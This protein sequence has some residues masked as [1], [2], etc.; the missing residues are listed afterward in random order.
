LH[1]DGIPAG[2]FK[3][4]RAGISQTWCSRE[5]KTLTQAEKE[6]YGA[7][8]TQIRAEREREE[9]ERHEQAR[10]RANEIWKQS[11]EVTTHPYLTGKQVK[12]FGIKESRGNIVVPVYDDGVIQSLQFIKPDGD[13][14]FLA[15][16]RKKGC[17]FVI[18]AKTDVIIC[19]TEGYATAVSIYEATGYM[20]IVAFDSVNLLSV[21]KAI[22]EKYPN[23]KLILCA[24]D[25]FL[26]SGN[27]GLTKAK[28]AA[29]AVGG[30]LAVPNFGDERMSNQTDF[31]DVHRTTSLEN[32]K[33]Q[34]DSAVKVKKKAK[35][36][37]GVDDGE[38]Q[39]DK[40]D[41]KMILSLVKAQASFFHD[42]TANAYA[43][44]KI[45]DKPLN[46][47]I[48]SQ[49]F[50]DWISRVCWMN[51]KTALKNNLL[52]DC[53]ATLRAE[54]CFDSPCY[55]VFARVGS[56]KNNIYLDLA[57]DKGLIVRINA[58]GWE[59][60]SN[61]PI[62]F[63]RI[64]SM[65]PL[66]QPESGGNI[67]RLFEFINIPIKS[68]KLVLAWLLECF[69]LNT[70]FP[71]LALSGLQGSAKSTTQEFLREL[72]DPSQPN[73]RG[74][75]KKREDLM[76]AAVNNYVM[77]LNNVSH[78]SAEQQDDLC[79]VSTGGGYS[80]RK[81][82][83]TN[84]EQTNDIKR[85]VILNGINEVVTAQDLID[86]SISVE[87]PMV[88]EE[89]RKTESVIKQEFEA[90]KPK[91][92]GALL[93]VLVATLKE[94]PKVRLDK[95][96]RMAD[97]AMLG[98]ALEKVMGWDAGSFLEDYLYQQSETR[99]AALEHS[100]IIMALIDYVVDEPYTGS[101]KKL[102]NILTTKQ[103][104]LDCGVL[105]AWPK[106]SKGLAE[107]LKRQQPALSELGIK[108]TFDPIRRM[109]G[110][111]VSIEKITSKDNAVTDILKNKK[112][113]EKQVHYVHEVH[114]ATDLVASEA[115][116]S[117]NIDSTCSSSS[118]SS[119]QV[120]ANLPTGTKGHELNE[121]NELI[122]ENFFKK[123]D[124]EDGMVTEVL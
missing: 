33:S 28:E 48:E 108:V 119:S 86:R 54:A 115:F 11:N 26:T 95:K 53:I 4:W 56:D 50:E 63:I 34:V 8:L 120:H 20:T 124:S 109:D 93:D 112:S 1:L 123:T 92:L 65:Q 29:L 52:K 3:D 118:L 19:I 42:K 40:I 17:Y 83:T 72:I 71:I 27:P 116:L 16:G 51:F 110:Y 15:G 60:I 69:R 66:V 79:C 22:R 78:L 45:G 102:H 2:Y 77:S 47:L 43:C 117:M 114:G 70:P 122:N 39:P 94:L 31:N 58:Q 61:S 81:L 101:F 24:D 113:F 32:V 67:N 97:F 13:K 107:A 30:Y 87:L 105:F 106:S 64:S 18:W 90:V 21:A 62:K 14:K 10:Q 91:L 76:V 41:A 80:T 73:L 68:Q 7:R 121:H 59:V 75:P 96:P 99:I 35:T 9:K 6:E 88:V 5:Y 74:A 37:D 104:T 23:A 82:Y 44:V 98:T 100:P 55:D 38:N 103:R 89:T 85:P 36:K 12:A 111:H 46:I 49:M 25:D 84:H 57:D